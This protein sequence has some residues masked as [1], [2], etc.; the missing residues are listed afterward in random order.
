M[1]EKIK[2]AVR[3]AGKLMLNDEKAEVFVKEGHAN[4]V[5]ER[6][7]AV[8]GYIIKALSEILPDSCFFAEEKKDNV[9]TDEYTWIIDPIDGTLNFIHN[10]RCSCISV[11]LC[12]NKKPVIGVIYDPYHDELYYAERGKGSWC[13]DRELHVADTDYNLSV[14]SLGSSP[15]DSNLAEKTMEAAK[16]FLL[17]CADIRRKGSAAL[18]L[19]DLAAGRLDGMFELKLSPWDYSAGFLIAEEAGAIVSTPEFDIPDYSAPHCVLAATPKCFDSMLKVIADV[20][21]NNK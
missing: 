20:Y 6:D 5:T 16:Y 8:Q 9:L 7:I 4:L 15:Y 10:R 11:A 14:I 13:N 12:K 19:C 1:I 18:E 3:E 17:Q 2:S 21:L